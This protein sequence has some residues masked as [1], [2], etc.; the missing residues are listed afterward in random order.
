MKLTS[1]KKIQT[2][3][4]VLGVVG[5]LSIATVISVL[6]SATES[7]FEMY[8][9]ATITHHD[10]DEKLVSTQIINNILLDA[11]KAYILDQTF[12]GLG[13][14]DVA[15]ATQIGAI[16]RSAG[17]SAD[18]SETYDID[19]FN[20]NHD[21]DDNSAAS[22]A[23]NC[24]T[25]TDISAT[26]EVA[27][28]GPLTFESE[29]NN[30]KNWYAGDTVTHIGICAAASDGVDNRGCQEILFAAVDTE[31]DITLQDGETVTV[32]YRFDMSSDQN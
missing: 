13:V 18:I 29:D 15:D 3:L 24:K 28:V 4:A 27:V 2:L 23:T 8:G 26:D 5:L 22:T 21:R 17:P 25:D 7:S 12:R 6:S 10:K 1:S 31:P 14:N 11:G 16:C 20:T 9:V 19:D 30:S 32:T